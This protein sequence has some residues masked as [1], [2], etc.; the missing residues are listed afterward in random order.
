MNSPLPVIAKTAEG[1]PFP[2]MQAKAGNH[3]NRLSCQLPGHILVLS[4]II[5]AP[6]FMSGCSYL[7]NNTTANTL[8][9]QIELQQIEHELAAEPESTEKKTAAEFEGQGD[10][11][12]QRGDINRAYMYYVK[13]LGVEP[14]N[15]SL[16]HKQGM[17][18]IKKNK[19]VEAEQ[20]YEKLFTL[21]EKDP[22]T[23]AGRSKA[24]F[25][26]GKFEEAEQGF[27]AALAIKSDDWQAHEYLGL[28][29]SQRQQYDK[30]ISRLKTALGYKPNNVS[31]GNNLAVTYYLN[32]DFNE[33]ARLFR[34]LTA[35]N[36]D[37]KIHNNLALAYF[38]LGQ[39][40]NALESFKKGASN[41][42]AAYNNMGREY[43]FA[44]KYN[45]AIEAFEKAIVLNPK[46]YA[47]AQK[48]LDL[49]RREL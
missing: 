41:E 37:K 25:G 35:K 30:A 6:V 7:Q 24:Y 29:Y 48:N 11:F 45:E 32:G 26:Q 10:R 12:L 31:V 46:Y 8:E 20:I 44:K 22:R 13:G 43:L 19:F 14:D 23:L 3:F 18:L 27:L 33:A 9:K 47:S 36:G 39:Y 49:A 28:I 16:L 17:L 1:R 21:A 5:L 40:E 42:A 34:N 38:Q 2:V 4:L 15:V